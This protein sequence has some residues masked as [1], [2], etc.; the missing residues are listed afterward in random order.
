MADHSE[1]VHPIERRHS[2][3]TEWRVVRVADDR[4][5][6]RDYCKRMNAKPGAKFVYR[7][8]R[9]KVSKL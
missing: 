9:G 8:Y 6:A 3:T 4:Q 7:V 5:D 2:L 1:T